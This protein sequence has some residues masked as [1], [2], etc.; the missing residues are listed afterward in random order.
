M[1]TKEALNELKKAIRIELIEEIETH[2]SY[3]MHGR[4]FRANTWDY[5]VEDVK[6]G[7]SVTKDE[8][9]A[10]LNDAFGKGGENK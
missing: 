9:F 4:Y 5:I 3:C 8:V 1:D 10:P 7:K 2:L 6:A